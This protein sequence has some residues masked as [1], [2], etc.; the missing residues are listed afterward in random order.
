[1]TITAKDTEPIILRLYL[2]PDELAQ[3]WAVAPKTLA[4]WRTE[5]TGP[6]YVKLSN[7]LVRYPIS[8]IE[9]FELAAGQG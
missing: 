5:G 1:M 3:R 9:T 4:K 8:E 6:H 2:R 7:G